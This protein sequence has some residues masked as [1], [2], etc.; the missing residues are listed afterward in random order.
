MIKSVKQP[1]KIIDD[2]FEAPM[3]V[4]HSALKLDYVEQDN[5]AYY[6]LRSSKTLDVINFDF[7][8]S[9]LSKLIRHATNKKRFRFLHCDYNLV[10]STV[11]SEMTSLIGPYNFAGTIFLNPEPVKDSGITF[12]SSVAGTVIPSIKIENIFNRCVLF[13]PEKPFKIE[14]FIGTTTEENSLFLNFYGVVDDE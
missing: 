11:T 12:F 10:D 8:D 14:K 9:L 2:F 5:N 1:V 13:H 3:L 4:R 7:F 6:G